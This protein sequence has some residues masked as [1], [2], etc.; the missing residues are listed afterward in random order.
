MFCSRCGAQ[1]DDDSLFCES[2]GV[3][4]KPGGAAPN[5][6]AQL[7]SGGAPIMEAPQEN[8]Q[9]ER[10]VSSGKLLNLTLHSENA[11]LKIF[12]DNNIGYRPIRKGEGIK[13]ENLSSGTHSV[14]LKCFGSETSFEIK[15]EKDTNLTI[16]QSV[17]T[18]KLNVDFKETEHFIK[19]RF[20]FG[21]FGV[22]AIMF[23]LFW[24]AAIIMT[25]I[26]DW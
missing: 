17:W 2:C 11:P 22:Y 1:I 5:P 25:I 14:S 9:N 24:I 8:A 13:F 10:Q 6:A 16:K 12:L 3:S 4:I 18:G 15:I 19:K 20:G 23:I 26:F 7:P 21:L